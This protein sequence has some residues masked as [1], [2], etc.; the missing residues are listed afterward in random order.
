M[1]ESRTRLHSVSSQIQDH[2]PEGSSFSTSKMA[3]LE[4]YQEVPSPYAAKMDAQSVQNP[5]RIHSWYSFLKEW[6]WEVLT[7][8]F[9]SAAFISIVFLL[10]V[11]GN[12]PLDHWKL[13]RIQTTTTV[14][15]LAQTAVSALIVSVSA[16]IGQLKWVWLDKGSQP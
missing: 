9:G 8:V 4:G 3:F 11:F 14:A 13:P 6:W 7:G 5:T 10:T 12:Q 2:T 16:C 1:D 15:A